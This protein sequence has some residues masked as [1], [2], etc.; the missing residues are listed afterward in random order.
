MIIVHSIMHHPYRRFP[1]RIEDIRTAAAS[2]FR[3]I[4]RA[5]A[6]I[7]QNAVSSF[8][9][10]GSDPAGTVSPVCKNETNG[11]RRLRSVRRRG[12]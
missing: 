5:G 12:W 4:P 10:T 2:E 6:E 9:D 8:P 11:I 1:V 3:F 7:E